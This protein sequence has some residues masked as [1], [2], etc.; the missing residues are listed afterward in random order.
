MADFEQS[1]APPRGETV[2]EIAPDVVRVVVPVPFRGLGAVNCY[3]LRGPGGWTVV[4][5]GLQTPDALAAWREALA[6]LGLQVGDI[7]QIVLTHHHP[8]HLGFAGRLQAQAR[9]VRKGDVPVWLSAREQEIVGIVW[10]DRRERNAA[11]E[12]FFARCGV[13]DAAA[14]NFQQREIDGMRR[15]LEPFPEAFHTLVPGATIPLGARTFEILLTPGHSDGHCAF[16]DAS[17][18]L[19][20][21][22]D[23]VLPHITP[24]IALWPDVEPDPLG[25]YRASLR[26]LRDL[27]VAL[28]LPGHGNVLRRWRQRIDEL[29]AHHDERLDAMHRAVGDGATVF[30][31]ARQ[32]FETDR[33]DRHQLRMAVA[34]TLAHLEHLVATGHLRRDEAE[35][36]D[37]MPR[38]YHP[39]A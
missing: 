24:N 37:R 39:T 38:I 34:E 5:T 32:V 3:L 27:D 23:Q 21:I 35:T 28:A 18:G 22:G 25:R 15:A 13:P 29:L 30:D 7:A 31:V 10:T 16:Y 4:D 8:D 26:D 11:T 12:A 2:T 9:A 1:I 20:L 36:S 14:A 19:L 33:L 6:T 17:D